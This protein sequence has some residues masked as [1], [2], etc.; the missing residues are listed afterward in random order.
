MS[1]VKENRGKLGDVVFSE[2]K[3]IPYVRDYVKN[4]DPGTPKQ[5]EV[6]TAF[7]SLTKLWKSNNGV[8]RMSWDEYV[9]SRKLSM[10]GYNAFIGANSKKER[11]GEPLE[12]FRPMGEEPL[13]DFAAEAG[14]SSGEITC[15]FT[16][17]GNGSHIT[18]FTRKVP[19]NGEI[20]LLSKHDAGSGTATPYTLTG[21]EPGA[22]YHVYGVV[23]DAAYDESAMVSAAVTAS[24]LAQA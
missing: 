22:A 1:L 7:T 5:K 17:P 21:L 12:L 11:A 2:W 6:R 18:F 9:N 3:G 23:T 8:M 4:E 16:P 14:A 19:G 20:E 13:A 15:T 10:T 24:A